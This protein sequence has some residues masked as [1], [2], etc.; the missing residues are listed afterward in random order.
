MSRVRVLAVIVNYG[1]EQ[2]S[3]LNQMV[4]A[5]NEFGKYDIDIIVHSNEAL[6][7][8]G[9]KEVKVFGLDDY[10][11]L[12]AT[13][14]KTISENKDLYD[15]YFYSENDLLI[16]E[17]HF[18]NFLSYSK[19]LPSNRIPGLIRFELKNGQKI[20]PDYHGNFD[21]QY[22]SVEKYNGKVFAHFT[23]LHQ[24]SFLLTNRQ[25][26]K[27]VNKFDFGK[28]V[29]DRIPI[30]YKI[31]RKIR[32]W[33]GLKT[34][35]YYIYDVL[36]KTCTDIYQY[37]GLKKVICISE[38]DENMIHHISDIYAKGDKGKYL[39]MAD[40]KIMNNALDQLQKKL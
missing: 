24:A 36:C 29:E 28:L 20:F 10:R 17:K 18:D 8:N 22:N 15:L 7:I 2:L 9:V 1:T 32:Y 4:S 11:Y 6:D 30:R 27:V 31:K 23:N 26:N 34:K 40:E 25:L 12:P 5:L 3:F 38:F 35:K 16:R 37:G 14:R 19:I 33:L 39:V 21:W 13:C